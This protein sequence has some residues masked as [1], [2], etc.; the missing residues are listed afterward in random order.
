MPDYIVNRVTI[1][2]LGEDRYEPQ[3]KLNEI[4]K[5]LVENDYDEIIDAYLRRIEGKLPL[6]AHETV[7]QVKA[8]L[9]MLLKNDKNDYTNIFSFNTVITM[10]KDSQTFRKTGPLCSSAYSDRGSFAYTKQNWYD[11]ST[12][13]WHTKWNSCEPKLLRRKGVLI[14]EFKTAWCDPEPV[15]Q[16]LSRKFNTFVLNEYYAEDFGKHVGR[17][18]YGCGYKSLNERYDDDF[19]KIAEIFGSGVMHYN[20]YR[21]RNGNWYYD[22]K[23]HDAVC[24]KRWKKWEMER[25]RKEMMAKPEIHSI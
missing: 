16:E 20:G 4:R 13:H 23:Y 19:N 14:Y 9:E 18:R 8:E 2:K 3:E 21:H 15:I 10:P 1:G 17:Y 12:E 25:K 7:D 6:D 22:E 5:S 24:D 11:W